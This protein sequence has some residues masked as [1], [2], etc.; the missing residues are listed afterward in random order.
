MGSSIHPLQASAPA[1][2]SF[3]FPV[4]GH[5]D[6][7]NPCEWKAPAPAHRKDWREIGKQ[8]VSHMGREVSLGN[9]RQLPL[10]KR[11]EVTPSF[12]SSPP[13]FILKTVTVKSGSA[14]SMDTRVSLR[15]LGKGLC[16]EDEWTG[17]NNRDEWILQ[18]PASLEPRT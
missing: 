14:F 1:G 9:L 10:A 17:F 4:S 3:I 5:S 13:F 7:Q 2:P 15:E 6:Q 16:L 12:Q 11:P 8:V 18:V